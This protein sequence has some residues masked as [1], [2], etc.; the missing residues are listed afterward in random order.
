[1]IDPSSFVAVAH[2][3]HDSRAEASVAAQL[4]NNSSGG[5]NGA[6]KLSAPLPT[7][8]SAFRDASRY[9]RDYC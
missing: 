5:V 4:S 6:V 1:M 3:S 7:F 9:V 8:G 2:R